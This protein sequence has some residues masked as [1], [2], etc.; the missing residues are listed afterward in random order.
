V[1]LLEVP[2]S[3]DFLPEAAQNTLDLKATEKHQSTID[4]FVKISS[5]IS[6]FYFQP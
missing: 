5:A 4:L 6:D 1:L 2:Y 3:K